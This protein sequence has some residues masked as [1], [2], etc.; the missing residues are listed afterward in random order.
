M[1]LET[2]KWQNLPGGIAFEKIGIKKQSLTIK[3]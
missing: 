3:K 2:K 1:P